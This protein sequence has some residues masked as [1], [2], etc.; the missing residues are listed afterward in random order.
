MAQ[1]THATT[2]RN[3]VASGHTSKG[4]RQECPGPGGVRSQIPA[5]FIE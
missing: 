2:A 3:Y 4:E 1:L 5:L